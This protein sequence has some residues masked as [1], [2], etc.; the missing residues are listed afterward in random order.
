MRVNNN[1]IRR[2]L[3]AATCVV[4]AAVVAAMSCC[5]EPS[6]DPQPLTRADSIRLGL[7][8]LSLE[9]DTAWK[10]INDYDPDGQ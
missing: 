1:T 4:A 9:V 3:L 8:N 2:L 6:D 5:G 7:I 10:A